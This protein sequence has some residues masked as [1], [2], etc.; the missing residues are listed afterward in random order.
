M[1]VSE[2]CYVTRDA[3]KKALDVKA[4]A[5][6]DDDVDRAIQA[7]SRAVEGQLNR[8]FYPIDATKYFAWPNYQYAAPWRLWLDAWELAGPA[9][10]VTSGGV[11]IPLNQCFFEP[12]NYGPPYTSLELNRAGNAAFG[13]GPTPQRDIAITGPFGYNLD[14]APAGTLAAA[15]SSTTG[16]T[17]TVANSA[18]AGVGDVVFIGTERMLLA[19]KATVTTGQTQ[20]GSLTNASND[21]TVGVSDGTK[22]A[23]GE[24]VVLDAESMLV[25]GTAPASLTV[26][27]AW[28]GSTI[29]VHSAAPIYA[30]RSWTVTR[31]AFGTTATT[32]LIGAAISRYTPPSLITQYA[33]A[34]AENNLLQGISGYARTVG[35]ADNLRPVS[36][37]ALADIRKQAV[38][39]YARKARRRT[40]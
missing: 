40:V 7:A 36:G 4:T 32:H 29:A 16:T 10:Q 26:K 8:R 11:T 23:V 27:R 20:Q 33:L 5:R 22:Y 13:N 39:A 14:S 17:V 37:Q 21:Q 9:T 25:I 24:V 19:D 6:S 35:A 34:E 28:D 2:P 30:T 1:A 3:L 31:G 15:V 18:A 38:N 12:I